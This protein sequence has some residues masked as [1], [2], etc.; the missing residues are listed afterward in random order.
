M[1]EQRPIEYIDA[2]ARRTPVDGFSKIQSFRRAYYKSVFKGALPYEIADFVN[3][4]TIMSWREP[5][6]LRQSFADPHVTTA[7]REEADGTVSY[8]G[9]VYSAKNVSSR[10]DGLIG[11]AERAA[12]L[13][14]PLGRVTGSR[15][16]AVREL[17]G[18]NPDVIDHLLDAAE[19]RAAELPI[20]VYVFD[21]EEMVIDVL[22]SN[23][24][25]RDPNFP[26][27]E[28]EFRSASLA[29]PVGLHCYTPEGQ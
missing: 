2:D 12:K 17:I 4:T 18:S 29:H 7:I 23:G 13:Y 24:L 26:A 1:S 14:T 15:Y 10:R 21:A 11:T 28:G 22:R 3:A 16:F 27:S 8:E 20:K 9:H 6:R 25:T 5:M 19:E